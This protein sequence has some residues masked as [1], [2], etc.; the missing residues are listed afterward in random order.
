MEMHC[1]HMTR[2]CRGGMRSRARRLWC[3]YRSVSECGGRQCCLI[4][5]SQRRCGSATALNPCET[6]QLSRHDNPVSFRPVYCFPL[7]SFPTLFFPFYSQSRHGIDIPTHH[8]P[9]SVMECY[10]A[11]KTVTMP[12]SEERP[13]LSFTNW[14]VGGSLVVNHR[15]SRVVSGVV[16]ARSRSAV[17]WTSRNLLSCSLRFT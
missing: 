15:R 1:Y 4:N 6:L 13:R 14:V 9:S 17:S 16:T 3:C 10:L 2:T 8:V 5:S 12:S 11:I 7:M